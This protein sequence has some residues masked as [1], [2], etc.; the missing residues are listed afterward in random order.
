MAYTKVKLNKEQIEYLID[1]IAIR[2]SKYKTQEE[3]WNSPEFTIIEILDDA[4]L[5]ITNLTNFNSVITPNTLVV[6]GF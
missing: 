1:L 4:L 6:K 5:A 3:W 2:K